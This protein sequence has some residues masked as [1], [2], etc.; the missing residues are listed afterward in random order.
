MDKESKIAALRGFDDTLKALRK[1]QLFDKL[2]G[3]ASRSGAMDAYAAEAATDVNG[4]SE[5]ED[6]G[7][8]E[9]P[10]HGLSIEKIQVSG[11]ANKLKEAKKLL[12]KR[13]GY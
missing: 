13:L 2:K 12:M 9:G 6:K 5:A 1:K 3:S 4:E 11:N 10:E 8:H 7:P